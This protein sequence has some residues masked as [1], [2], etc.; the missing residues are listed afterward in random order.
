MENVLEHG[1]KIYEKGNSKAVLELYPKYINEIETSGKQRSS[2]ALPAYSHRFSCLK[3]VRNFCGTISGCTTVTGIDGNHVKSFIRRAQPYNA[4]KQYELAS[5][6][7]K[8]FC[9]FDMHQ[10]V[11]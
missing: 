6:D 1:D 10:L 3:H 9:L 4:I 7:I 8:L 2:L 11:G 5:K